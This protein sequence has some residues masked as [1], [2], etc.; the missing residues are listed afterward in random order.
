MSETNQ[1]RRV[2]QRQRVLPELVEGRVE[3]RALP[4]VLPDECWRFQTS[5]QPS[6]PV[7]LWAPRSKQHVSPD[8]SASAGVGSSSRRHRLMK[9]SCVAERSFSAE[10]RHFVMKA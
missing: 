8:G 7:S 4:L 6:P 3:V 5:A 10:A 1:Q 9:C 2:P